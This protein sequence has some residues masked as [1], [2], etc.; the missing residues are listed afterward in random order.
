MKLERKGPRGFE[1]GTQSNRKEHTEYSKWEEAGKWG[2][3]GSRSTMHG[4]SIREAGVS[5]SS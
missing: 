2:R 1:G 5:L 4:N 3:V